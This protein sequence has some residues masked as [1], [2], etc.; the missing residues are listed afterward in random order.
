[1]SPLSILRSTLVTL[2][3]VF[4]SSYAYASDALPIGTIQLRMDP[5]DAAV[6]LRKDRYDKSSFAV[7]VIDGDRKL[8]GRIKTSGSA[9][10]SFEKRSFTIK[11]DKGLKWH[12]QSRISLNGMG[13][14]LTLMRNRMVW[15]IYHAI[16]VVGPQTA[17]HRVFLNGK[18]QGIYLQ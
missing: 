7:T 5:T 1:M 8:T 10:R 11:L 18:P 3:V 6:L 17:Y 4:G 14:D 16:G 13:S 12:G 2:T 9:S 15:D